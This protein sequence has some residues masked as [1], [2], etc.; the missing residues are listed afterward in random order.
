MVCA[1]THVN[2]VCNNIQLSHMCILLYA[3]MVD[4]NTDRMTNAENIVADQQISTSQS[5]QNPLEQSVDLPDLGP[6]ATEGMP[7]LDSAPEGSLSSIVV[8]VP[9]N[10][11]IEDNALA[12]QKILDEY[13]RVT[14]PPQR[15]KDMNYSFPPGLFTT[16]VDLEGS[17]LAFRNLL[18]GLETDQDL[19]D[20]LNQIDADPFKQSNIFS[21]LDFDIF[22]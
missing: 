4:S 14:A 3:R 2:D 12:A 13:H 15:K 19:Q 11:T 6:N 21:D 18:E 1:C 5:Q 20:L 10:T 16:E 17:E 7:A 8:S 22:D 9:A